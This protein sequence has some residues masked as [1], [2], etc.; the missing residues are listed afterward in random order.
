MEIYGLPQPLTGDE[1][2]TITQ[3]Q[4]D[5]LA[6]CSMPLSALASLFGPAS[7]AAHLST[8]EPT[9]PGIPWNNNGVVSIS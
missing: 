1:L 8:D 9:A 3:K 2:V 7:W 5:L 4:G 6:T